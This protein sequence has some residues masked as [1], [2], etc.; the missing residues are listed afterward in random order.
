MR[1]RIWH[2]LSS[3]LLVVALCGCSPSLPEEKR[4]A[5]DLRVP[6]KKVKSWLDKGRDVLFVDI[7]AQS[8][9]RASDKQIPNSVRFHS[10]KSAED[11]ARTVDKSRLIVA[12][13]T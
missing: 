9:W 4:S 10:Y 11:L 13:C 12:Y 2:V 3:A 8:S 1:P 5:D 7:R 6:P